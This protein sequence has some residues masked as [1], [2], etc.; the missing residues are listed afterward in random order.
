M[1]WG[2]AGE[3]AQHAHDTRHVLIGKSAGAASARSALH[4]RRGRCGDDVSSSQ[5][6]DGANELHQLCRLGAL[7]KA[8]RQQIRRR[9]PG[10]ATGES[11]YRPK[12]ALTTHGKRKQE[13]TRHPRPASTCTPPVLGCLHKTVANERL[14]R[15]RERRRARVLLKATRTSQRCR[16]RQ[17]RSQSSPHTPTQRQRDGGITSSVIGTRCK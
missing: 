12:Q 5:L 7:E 16:P 14:K 4:R 11:T 13:P 9:V 10:R 6:W 17:S 2:G 3:P 15:R 1:G 8:R